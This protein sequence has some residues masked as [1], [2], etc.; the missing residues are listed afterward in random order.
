MS[1]VCVREREREREL[2][3]KMWSLNGGY[4][5]FVKFTGG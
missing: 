5:E 3:G 4:G 2:S 1:G